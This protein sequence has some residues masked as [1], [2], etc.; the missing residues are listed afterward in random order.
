MEKKPADTIDPATH[1][2]VVPT[3]KIVTMED[4]E[5]FKS[6]STVKEI[7]TFVVELQKSVERKSNNDVKQKDVRRFIYSRLSRFLCR[8]TRCSRTC[9]VT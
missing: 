6:S 7:V 4:L 1:E 9:P 5:K 2:F 3:K 8:S